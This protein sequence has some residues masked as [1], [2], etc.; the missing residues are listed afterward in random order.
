[1]EPLAVAFWR[2]NPRK[3]SGTRHHIAAR[4]PL[5]AVYSSHLLFARAR[6]R[7]VDHQ[8]VIVSARIARMLAERDDAR[9]HLEANL[10]LES[11]V[12]EGADS[13]REL[14]AERRRCRTHCGRC[15]LIGVTNRGEDS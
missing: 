5:P 6:R 15:V 1:M 9:V 8:A 14:G 12:V 13:L 7:E 3:A 10:L 4:L 2:A 11:D